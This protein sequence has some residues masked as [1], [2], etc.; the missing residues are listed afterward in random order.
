[1]VVASKSGD[2]LLR[3][4]VGIAVL[5]LNENSRFLRPS[6]GRGSVPVEGVSSGWGAGRMPSLTDP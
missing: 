2:S 6:R 3:Q 1:M 5:V 4:D